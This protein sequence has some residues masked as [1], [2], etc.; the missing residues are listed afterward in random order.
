MKSRGSSAVA[1]AALVALL[2]TLP[3]G[4]QEAAATAEALYREANQ[5]AEQGRYAEACPKFAASQKLDPGF[6]TAFN[7]GRC[8][9][10][11]GKTASAWASFQEAAGLAK[12][13]GQADR[14]AKA[15]AAAVA[16]EPKL[17]RLIIVVKAPP[18]GLSV[19]RGG[20]TVDAAAF[21]SALPVDPGA[22]RIEAT[23]PG[24]RPF[25]TEVSTGGPGKPVTVEI[26]PLE[27]APHGTEGGTADTGAR[28]RPWAPQRYA[29]L[30]VGLGGVVGLVVGAVFGMQAIT[31]KNDSNADG[32]CDAS[33]ACDAIGKALRADGIRSGNISTGLFVAG[34][35]M[36]AGGVVLMVTAPPGGKAPAS[37]R[38]SAG[39]AIGPGSLAL[40]GRW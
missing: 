3:A 26:P 33:D 34:G 31:K 15:T 19:K 2:F 36:V 35:V 18:P 24:K 21:G 23:A 16:L 4:A 28:A 13:N 22:Y 10:S 6:G 9:E 1:A 5:L 20:V 14:E 32:H 27:D 11:L 12:T 7:L 17:E 30:G 38:P 37:T 8:L 39:L 29:G 40:T 25:S